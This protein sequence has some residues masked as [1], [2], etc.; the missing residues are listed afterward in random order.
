MKAIGRD[1]GSVR[2]PLQDMTE[3]DLADLKALIETAGIMPAD[4][5]K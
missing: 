4:A 2:T 3:Q 5:N 1:C